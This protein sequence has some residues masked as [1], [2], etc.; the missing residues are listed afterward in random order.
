[1]DRAEIKKVSRTELRQID[2]A[3]IKKVSR[4]E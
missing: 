3:E 2:S 1:M 4:T